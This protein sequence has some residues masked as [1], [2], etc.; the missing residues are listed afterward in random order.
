ML[1]I[2]LSFKNMERLQDILAGEAWSAGVSDWV[3][4]NF[5]FW[6]LDVAKNVA[7]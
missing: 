6:T 7:R 5:P 2:T 4:D 1:D 3:W